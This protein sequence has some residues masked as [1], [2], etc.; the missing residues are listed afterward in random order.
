MKKIL[1][2]MAVLASSMAAN[3]QVTWS[4][5]S[6]LTGA[7]AT[8]AISASE[9]ELGAGLTND[10]IAKY[11]YKKGGTDTEYPWESLK[12]T[13]TNEQLP[14]DAT[15]EKAYTGDQYRNIAEATA[16]AQAMYINFKAEAVALEDNLEVKD[17]EFDATRVGTDAVLVNVRVLGNDGAYTSK[18]LID[19]SNAASVADGGA[20]QSKDAEGDAWMSTVDAGFKPCRNDDSKADTSEKCY[21]HFKVPAP[22]D[23]PED[24]YQATVQIAVYGISNNKSAYIHGVKLNCGIAGETAVAGIA[25]AKAEKAAPVK[26][27]TA[28]G[29]QIGNYNIAGQQ[30]K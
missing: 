7:S 16:D 9:A 25:E 18:W 3:A 15:H 30:V 20:W 22:T 29:I 2:S 26:V 5:T 27:I 12:V 11:K 24:L 10:G 13:P 6:N 21:T 8:E 14:A 23:L 28:N 4:L 19:G 1:L 17:I